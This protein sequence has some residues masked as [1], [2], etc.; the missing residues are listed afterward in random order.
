MARPTINASDCGYTYYKYYFNSIST[1]KKS[2]NYLP[3][4]VIELPYSN[5]ELET[6]YGGN[7]ELRP[8]EMNSFGTSISEMLGNHLPCILSMS[9]HSGIVSSSYPWTSY[10]DGNFT[11]RLTLHN[12][13][14]SKFALMDLGLKKPSADTVLNIGGN[15]VELAEGKNYTD[16]TQGNG[17]F[18]CLLRSTS[19]TLYYNRENGCRSASTFNTDT[20]IT[21]PSADK[22]GGITFNPPFTL[23]TLTP[24]TIWESDYDIPLKKL[25]GEST[26][27]DIKDPDPNIDDSDG[28]K[29]RTPTDD[30][31]GDTID[32]DDLPTLSVMDT[33]LVTLYNPTVKELSDLGHFL[34]SDAFSVDTFKKLF[35]DPFDTL[36][37][38]SIL[39]VTPTVSGRHD[40]YFGNIDSGVACNVVANQFLKVDM[41]SL[42]LNETYASAFDYAPSTQ[43]DIY[44][45]FIGSHGLNTND[46]MGSTIHLIYKFDLLSGGCIAE[47]FI[48]HTSQG[49]KGKGMKYTK[50]MGLAY[51]FTGQCSCSIP[52][53]SNNYNGMIHSII[54]SIG[55][56]G[57]IGASVATGNPALGLASVASSATTIGLQANT[58]TVQRSGSIGS[59]NALLSC[60][61]PYLS[62]QRA[63]VCKPGHFYSKRGIPSQVYVDKISDVGKGNYFQIADCADLHASGASDTELSEIKSILTSGAIW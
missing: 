46:V 52:L 40:I 25:I 27:T 24:T 49:N 23:S 43:V 41:G 1:G 18:L 47:L 53:T 15:A 19:G 34:W 63:H 35:S 2:S 21:S 61:T 39:P 22:F 26:K 12:Y 50:N 28:D 30:I 33:G 37:G 7:I 38:L 20:V 62:V 36:L 5:S 3:I 29:N 13:P 45:P 6:N 55:T 17:V 16:E 8:N 59:S 4:I 58:P 44:L 10:E 11:S 9:R 14:D 56:V 42:T 60:L 31:G 54:Q 57:A 32:D 51:T 48:N